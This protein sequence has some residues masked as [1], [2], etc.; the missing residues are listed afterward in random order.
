MRAYV[1]HSRAL[2][3]EILSTVKAILLGLV[4]TAGCGRFSFDPPEP[5]EVG[6]GRFH[7]CALRAN[8]A[9]AC[10]GANEA[11]Q[12]GDSSAPIDQAL[13]RDNGAIAIA[14]TSGE[15]HSCAI[16]DG[17]QVS[18]WGR[19]TRGQLGTGD[20]IDH[21]TPTLASGASDVVEIAA[22]NEHT[23][24]RLASG[25]VICAGVDFAAG[26]ATDRITFM[27]VADLE[28]VVQIVA[29]SWYSCALRADGR[30]ACWGNNF[31]G[32]LGV[33]GIADSVTPVI[34]DGIADA[35]MIAGGNNHA[36][37]LRATGMVSCWGRNR[38]GNLGNNM[39]VDSA[40]PV[41][42]IGISGAT[43]ID[44]GDFYSCARIGAREVSCWGNNPG[45]QLGNPSADPIR[46]LT[47][48]PVVG[49]PPFVRFSSGGAHSCVEAMDGALTCWGFNTRGQLGDSTFVPRATPAPVQAYP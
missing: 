39:L 11:A 12:L 2:D 29:G 35:I 26:A 28:D 18:C 46:S 45:F 5:L 15:F 43:E 6:L 3:C 13:P 38:D 14:V 30:V 32:M 47:P 49:L 20:G 27:P 1:S 16:H 22:G 33:P 4:A 10:W 34:V 48:V 31:F 21:P 24:G 8:G 17:G 19:N 40:V 23:C 25:G 41:D 36:C 9:V 37:A 7:S 44:A 42:V